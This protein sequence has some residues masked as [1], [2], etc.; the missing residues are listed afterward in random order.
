[1]SIHTVIDRFQSRRQWLFK[2][3][4]TKGSFYGRKEFN[5]RTNDLGLQHGRRFIALRQQHGGR[6]VM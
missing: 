6:D 2:F 3:I 5:S 4:E 1:M